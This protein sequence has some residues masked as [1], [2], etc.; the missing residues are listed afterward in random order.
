MSESVRHPQV[1]LLGNGINIWKKGLSWASLLSELCTNERIIDYLKNNYSKK[2]PMS[3]QALLATDDDVL[4][5]IRRYSEKDG[6]KNGKDVKSSQGVYP[7]YGKVVNEDQMKAL[8]TLLSVPYDAVLTTNYSYELELASMGIYEAQ[9]DK[10]IKKLSDALVRPVEPKYM[11]KSYNHAAFNGVD[12][13]VFHIHG[14]ARKPN[15]II[16]SNDNYARLMTRII[17]EADR[18]AGAGKENQGEKQN[19][20]Y[21]SWVDYFLLGDVYVLG[22]GFDFAESDLWWLLKRKKSEKTEKGKVYYYDLWTDGFNEK[23]ELLKLM[24]VEPVNY[25]IYLEEGYTNIAK[26]RNNERFDELYTRAIAEIK[27]RV[28]K[29]LTGEEETH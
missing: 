13:K 24:G 29:N 8:Q 23:V 22:F 20:S 6:K 2:M 10:T 28:E 7:F 27:E 25:D 17:A 14:E 21:D 15:S 1:L 16:L 18:H 4:G 9:S 3:M 12:N 26:K 19:T 11:M 5:A